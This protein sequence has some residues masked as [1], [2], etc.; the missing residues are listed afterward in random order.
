MSVRPLSEITVA[1][2]WKR[3]SQLLWPEGTGVPVTQ[4]AEMKKA[5]YGAFGQVLVMLRD[6]LSVYPE[7]EGTD[8]M[9]AFLDEITDFWKREREKWEGPRR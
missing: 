5:F 3:F 4:Y 9:T 7:Q 2:E 6:E 1:A 8:K